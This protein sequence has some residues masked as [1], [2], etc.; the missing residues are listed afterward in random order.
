[1][2][3]SGVM[4]LRCGGCVA[5]TKSWEMPGY[6]MPASPMRPAQGWAATVSTAS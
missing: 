6:E 4:A 3:D 5:A 1:M 2:T